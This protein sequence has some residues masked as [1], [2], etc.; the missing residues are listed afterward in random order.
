MRPVTVRV[1]SATAPNSWSPWIGLNRLSKATFAVGLGVKLSSGASLTYSV[2]HTFDPIYIPTKEWSASQSA[3]TVLTV[4][5]INHGLSVGD[6]VQIDLPA[7]A[8]MV[9]TYLVTSVTNA[10]V[11]VLTSGTSA[12]ATIAR[13][14]A[15]MHTARVLPHATLAAQTSSADGNYAFPPIA[16]R[17]LVT[18]YVSGFADLTV[19]QA[20]S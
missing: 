11:F 8:S 5:Q 17:L 1:A 4:T 18:T 12:T 6:W 2:Q 15:D 13:G 14:V 9:G 3:S 19:I 7:P 20:G 16:T 10:D